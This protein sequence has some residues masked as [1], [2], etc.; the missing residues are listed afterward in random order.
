MKH[1]RSTIGWLDYLILTLLLGAAGFIIY[2]ITM[3]LE[4]NWNWG[5]IP[6]YLFFYDT[7]HEKWTANYL[8]HGLLTTIK[9]SLWSSLLAVFLGMITALARTS[10]SFFLQLTS[11]CYIELMRNLPPLVI[12]FLFYFFLA[13][14]VLPLMELDQFFS[15]LSPDVQKLV[16][17]CFAPPQT[18]VP[19]IW[20]RR[21]ARCTC[22]AW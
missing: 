7:E 22:A 12:I 4:Y 14:Q 20:I 16:T 6:Q 13:D 2:R 1:T 17:Y 11:R 3:R 21:G 18:I 5:A 10:S 15:G 8:V 9:L 19:F